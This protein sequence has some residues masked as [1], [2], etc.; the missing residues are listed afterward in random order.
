[1]KKLQVLFVFFF[2]LVML[3]C[4]FVGNALGNRGQ[5]MKQLVDYESNGYLGP[6]EYTSKKVF[7]YLYIDGYR[8]QE[9]ILAYTV[10]IN[11]VEY[12]Y[13]EDFSYTETFQ[14]IIDVRTS[15][16]TADIKLVFTFN[17]P[18]NPTIIEYV[19]SELAGGVYQGSFL[20]TGTKMFNIV[21]GGGSETATE[22]EDIMHAVHSG[23]VV[24]WPF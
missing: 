24:G 5:T 17:L 16:G 22:E 2:A 12:S 23:Q 4:P 10:T 8:P 11:G 1:M 14:M 15:T 7:P 6:S 20:V 9:E 3:A 13:P 19:T 18:G 21:E